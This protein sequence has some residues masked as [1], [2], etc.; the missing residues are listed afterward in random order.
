M[1]NR[2]TGIV[3][4]ELEKRDYKAVED[5]IRKTW[6]YDKLSPNP[7]DARRMAALYLRSCL[8]RKTFSRVAVRGDKVLG[9]IMARSEAA[10]GRIRLGDDLRQTAA[11]LHLLT[12]KSGRRIGRM[13]S[14]FDKTDQE[15]LKE[16]GRRFDGELVFFA[17]SEEER[18]KGTGKQLLL[19][20]LAYLKEEA[21]SE[22][23][24]YTDSTCNYPF[25]ESQGFLRRGEKTVDFR[26]AADYTLHMFIYSYSFGKA[27]SAS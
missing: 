15:L 6:G 1:E 16:C 21:V 14:G 8:A 2:G 7:K 19:R 23:Y 13:F 3:Y 12:T 17:L 25:Y 10:G 11:A 26:P 5:I 20:A 9:I 18:G 24:L 4:R 22:F 27:D